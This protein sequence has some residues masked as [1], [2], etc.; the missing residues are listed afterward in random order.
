MI[1]LKIITLNTGNNSVLGGLLSII[2][3]ENP[4]IVF[5]QEISV[6]TGQLKLFVAKYGYNAEANT[7]LLDITRLGTGLVW[8]SD[9]PITEVTSVIDCRAQSAKL[10]SYN[11]IN[12]YAPSGGNNKSQRRSFFGQDIFRLIRGI[13]ST[14]YPL[15][16]GDYNCILSAMDTENNFEDKKCPA[17]K[18]LVQGFNYSDAFRLVKPSVKEYTFH[19]KKCAP[20]RLDR[21]YVPQHCVQLVQDVSHHASLSDHHYVVI[22]LDLPNID[23]IPLPP[24]SPPLYWKLNT[25][26]LQDDDFKENFKDFYKKLQSKK[27]EYHDIANWWDLHAKP[28]IRQFCMNVSQRLAYVKKNTKRFLFSYLSLVIKRGNWKEVARVRRKIKKLLWKESMGFVVRSRH[29]ENIEAEKSSL[30]FLNR[31]NKNFDKS[32]LHELKIDGQVTSD[33]KIIEAEVLLYFGALFNGH[34]DRHGTDTGQSFQPDYSDLPE[35]LENLGCLSNQSQE[36]LVKNLSYE[37]ISFIVLKDCDHNKS[38]G[39]DGLPYEFYQATWDIIG[40]DF[41]EVLHVQLQRFNLIESDRHGATRLTS[42]VDGVPSVTELRPITLLNCDYKIL[43]KAF[44]KRLC[45]VM[46]E[47]IKSGQLCSVKGKNI[48]F[49]ISNMIS[50]IDYIIAHKIAAFMVTFDMFKAYDRVMLDYLVKVMSAMKFPADFIK[51][52]LM[53]HEGATTSFLLSFLTNPIKVLFSIRQGD[54]LSMLLYII[55]IEPLLLKIHRETVGLQLATVVQKDEDYCD[56]LNFLSESEEDLKIIENIFV[57][58]EDVSGAILSRSSKSKVM[59]LGAW[60]DRVVWPLQWLQPKS[61]LKIFGFQITPVYKTTLERCWETCFAGFHKLLMS[62]SSRQLETLVQ[63]VEVLRL[64]ATS[65][66]WYKAS[67]LP[68]PVKFARKFEAAMVKFL[69]VGRLEK[70]KIDEMK[71][72]YMFGGLNLPCVISKADSLMLSQVCRMLKNPSSKEYKHIKYWMGLYTG[73]YFPDMRVGPHAEMISPYFQHIRAV[74][75]GGLILGD[76]RPEALHL[77]TAK[78]LYKGFTTTFPPPKITFKYNIEWDHVWFRLHHPVLESQAKDTLFMIIH[79][80][81]PNKERIHRFN[82]IASPLC[83]ACGVSADNVHLFCECVNVREAWFWLRQ[84]LLGLLPQNGGRISNFEFL[85]LMY[86]SGPFDSEILWLI[87]VYILFV[88]NSVICKKKVICQNSVQSEVQQKYLDHH[89]ARKP[90]LG[91]ISGL[92]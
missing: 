27:S 47:I 20:S 19:R 9:V 92:F 73:E 75:V 16:G 85:N 17:L 8:R 62:W 60:K 7:D 28:G 23:T 79:N 55:Y 39:L 70:L 33:K 49:G 83:T 2:K 3:M 61:E 22:I 67:A 6:T 44:V 66:L 63:R 46:P 82:M 5:L 12:L 77:V 68:L 40:R 24:K 50:S 21:F 30:F 58:F 48:L 41:A 65:R 57:K 43:S 13:N 88:W 54:P 69:W 64:F 87:G 37:E 56:D 31:E 4:D 32:S 25:S 26:I 84:R 1:P 36:N 29:K 80:I 38:P 78:D 90:P 14:S 45:P 11:L 76:I 42:K 72:P 10:G 71:N 35:F 91:H 59:G 74:L 86:D 52:M 89:E 18:D 51:W 34:H 15:L 53:L 81:V